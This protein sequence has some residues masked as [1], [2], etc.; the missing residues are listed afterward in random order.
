[1][2]VTVEPARDRSAAV[3]RLIPVER[4]SVDH[5]AADEMAEGCE[6]FDVRVGDQ[7][8][9]AL[10]VDFSKPIAWVNAAADQSGQPAAAVAALE[11]IAR[12]RGHRHI[13]FSTKRPGMLRKMLAMGYGVLSAHIIKEL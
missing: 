1:M 6:L 3:R 11:A 8:T 12:D 10:A 5:A 7:I 9:G 2:S 13:G 4:H